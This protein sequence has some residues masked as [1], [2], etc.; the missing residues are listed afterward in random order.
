V[1]LVTIS[2]IM[3]SVFG[4]RSLGP[5]GSFSLSQR[6]NAR[7][8]IGR[9]SLTVPRRMRFRGTPYPWSHT[10]E[11]RAREE[12]GSVR[13]LHGQMSV[14]GQVYK[15]ETLDIIPLNSHRAPCSQPL[16]KFPVKKMAPRDSFP[17]TPRLNAS[18]IQATL[19]KPTFWI[20]LVGLFFLLH[21]LI[22]KFQ[23]R[24]NGKKV[25]SKALKALPSPPTNLFGDHIGKFDPIAPFLTFQKWARNYG[26]IFIVRM[27]SQ[28][29][30]AINDPVLAKE[31]LEKR[32][33]NYGSRKAPYVG[34]DLLS[35]ASRIAFTPSGAQHKAYRKQMANIMSITKAMAA[36]P[37]Q[38]LESRQLLQDFLQYSTKPASSAYQDV[39]DIF[40][41]YTSSIMM[42]LA[43][44]HRVKQLNDEIVKT[45]FEIMA[46]FS[47]CCLPGR[48]YVDV[49]PILKRLPYFMRTWE[50]GTKAKV[51]WQNTFFKKLLSRVE[52]QKAMGIPNSGL[53][54]NLVDERA[55]MSAE[56][57]QRKYL[58]DVSISY[59]A[60]TIMEAGADTTSNSLMN[61]LLGM[62]LNPDAMR[63]GQAA[64]DAV[65]GDDHLPTFDDINQMQ[66]VRQIVKETLRWRP[67]VIMGVPHATI[68][69]DEVDGCL[70]PGG[71]VVFGNIWH[72]NQNPALYHD[73]E[74]FLPDRY[75]G[76]TRTAYEY[77]TEP[78]ALK[79]DN[80]TF[81]WGRRICPGIHVAENSLNLVVARLLWAFDVLPAQ[82]EAGNDIQVDSDPT[83]AYE[84]NVIATPLPFPVRFVP[85]SD[86]RAQIVRDAFQEAHEAWAPQKLDLFED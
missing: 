75:D 9:T 19:G 10:S 27:G 12:R 50:H 70:L 33:S 63:K 36:R 34:F 1:S 6:Y 31:L 60:Q 14:L 15:Q 4:A 18:L 30:V 26:K 40:R 54:R 61:F 53:I 32:G 73:P 23:H 56:E 17:N 20:A 22:A 64:A 43:F 44:G 74:S 66:Y 86:K 76:Y 42:T 2:G 79:R 48:Y 78:D 49:F 84:N 29:I 13:S 83:T 28:P 37:H 77:S 24:S 69:D 5:K 11:I 57:I 21:F 45:V 47:A 16:K 68:A 65:C 72:M 59:Q 80:Y 52:Y 62:L 67:A 25:G 39:Q 8:H 85:R 41:R 7:S 55:G 71:S 81:G 38:E 3:C 51:E 58:D 82:D 46:D 35:R